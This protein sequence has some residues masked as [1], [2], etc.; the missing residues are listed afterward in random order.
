MNENIH[1]SLETLCQPIDTLKEMPG[2]PRRGDVEAVRRSYETFGQRKPIV[3]TEDGTVIAGNH[4]LKAARELGWEKIA[5]VLTDDDDLKAKAFALADNKTSDLGTY[6]DEALTEILAELVV[7]EELLAATAYSELEIRGYLGETVGLDYL[8]GAVEDEG[9]NREPSSGEL[10]A[11]ADVSIGEPKSQVLNGD[12]YRIGKHVLVV[13]SVL[14][15]W[16]MWKGHLK[17]DA[18]FVPYPGPFAPLS[19]K[20]EE[21]AL[22]MVQPDPYIAGHIIDKWKAINGEYEVEKI[23]G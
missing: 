23:V 15:D 11:L 20:A 13:C 22:V 1:P 4:Q 14:K 18:L 5:V 8:G 21:R 19:L 2:N 7:D 16:T 3:A 12:T 9:E 17:G 10:L 6:D